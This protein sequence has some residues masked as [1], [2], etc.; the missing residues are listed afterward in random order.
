MRSIAADLCEK[1]V[2]LRK[3]VAS[4][5]RTVMSM[6]DQAEEGNCRHRHFLGGNI[7]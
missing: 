7:R 3:E 5:V 1:P 2:S 6:F 4:I